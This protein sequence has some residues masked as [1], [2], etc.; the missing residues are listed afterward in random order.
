MSAILARK[1]KQYI[2]MLMDACDSEVEEY[3]L[4]KGVKVTQTDEKESDMILVTTHLT[5]EEL[6][7]LGCVSGVYRRNT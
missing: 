3:L 4:Q 2:L 7:D 5:K 6:S 1:E